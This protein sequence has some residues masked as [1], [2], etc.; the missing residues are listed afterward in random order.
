MSKPWDLTSLRSLESAAEWIRK[1]SGGTL[2]LVVRSE[3]IAFAVD[4]LVSPRSAREMV[5]LVMPEVEARLQEQRLEAKAKARAK[6][7]GAM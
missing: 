1:G 7:M 6:Q 2:V 4:P 5:E 3:D